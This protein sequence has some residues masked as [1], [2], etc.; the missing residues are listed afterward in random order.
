MKITPHLKVVKSC[1]KP[2]KL[3]TAIVQNLLMN[4]KNINKPNSL[5]EAVS[6]FPN[7]CSPFECLDSLKIRNTLTSRIILNI[8]KE[9][10]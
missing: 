1:Y 5:K 3:I 7:I 6:V 4:R 2:E 10:A 9:A 8:V